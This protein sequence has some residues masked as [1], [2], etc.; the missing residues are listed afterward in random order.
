VKPPPPR[1]AIW[2]KRG[3]LD[4]KS[5]AKG[6]RARYFQIYLEAAIEALNP[7]ELQG[8]CECVYRTAFRHGYDA[9]NH[10]REVRNTFSPRPK[11][12]GS[13]KQP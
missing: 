1:A 12:R 6:R 2:W 8:E 11:R 10:A 4:G 13:L 9:E 7:G 3:I 5:C